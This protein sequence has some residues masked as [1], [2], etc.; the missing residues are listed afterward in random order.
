MVKALYLSIISKLLEVTAS[1]QTSYSPELSSLLVSMAYGVED[2]LLNTDQDCKS[3]ASSPD[4][5]TA[6]ARFF[7]AVALHLGKTEGHVLKTMYM[8]THCLMHRDSYVREWTLKELNSS[9]PLRSIREAVCSDVLQLFWKEKDED[10]LIQVYSSITLT[11]EISVLY[12]LRIGL[13]IPNRV[14]GAA[15]A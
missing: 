9:L 10:V 15:W 6:Q 3:R 14:C 2:Q 7:L 1:V 4:L 12:P 8:L 13:R 5:V 11:V